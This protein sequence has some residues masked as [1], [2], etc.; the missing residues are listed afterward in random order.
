[1]A[2]TVLYHT[3]SIWLEMEFTSDI[4]LKTSVCADY[5]QTICKKQ[6]N[7]YLYNQITQEFFFGRH[8]LS[9]VA[10]GIFCMSKN[11]FFGITKK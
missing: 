11:I 1:M 6:K 2:R 9:F 5:T 10:F 3:L 4:L 7:Q 8:F